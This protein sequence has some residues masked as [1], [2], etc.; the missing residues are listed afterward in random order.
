M[1]TIRSVFQNRPNCKGISLRD[2]TILDEIEIF[3]EENCLSGTECHAC[4]RSTVMICN[5]RI[6]T[7]KSDDQVKRISIYPRGRFTLSRTDEVLCDP[8]FFFGMSSSSASRIG[9]DFSVFLRRSLTCQGEIYFL[10]CPN[11]ETV[12]DYEE[13]TIVRQCDIFD[14]NETSCKS[15]VCNKSN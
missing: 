13:V 12:H 5:E 11:F 1:H 3:L 4:V 15:K 10:L 9:E 8:E 6:G 2:P 14:H 7:N